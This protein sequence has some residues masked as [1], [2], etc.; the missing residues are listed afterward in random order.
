MLERFEGMGVQ[1]VSDEIA[2]PGFEQAIRDSDA[3]VEAGSASRS[4][5]MTADRQFDL[6]FVYLDNKI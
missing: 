5:P 1:T 3:N 6:A 4:F 2:A